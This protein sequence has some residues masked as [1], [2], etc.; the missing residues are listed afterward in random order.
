[1]VRTVY[2]VF[3][4]FETGHCAKTLAM[5]RYIYDRLGVTGYDWIMIVDD[6]FLVRLGCLIIRL[7]NRSLTLFKNM[8]KASCQALA[9]RG[10][11]HLEPL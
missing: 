2:F 6:D 4:F 3:L 10:V 7:N 8:F 11:Y 1:M 5:L 9:K